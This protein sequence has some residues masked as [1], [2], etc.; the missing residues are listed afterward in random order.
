MNLQKS[1]LYHNICDME[2][3]SYIKS[4]FGVAADLMMSGMKYLGYHIKPCGYKVANW[5]WLV[6]R[7]FKRIYGW[8]FRCL[9]MGGHIILAQVVLM[10]LGVYW[11]HLFHLPFFIMKS[12]NR[13]TAK[14]L[15]THSR[16]KNK[17]YLAKM[18][19]ITILKCMG[20]WGIMNLRCF[21]W[22]LLLKSLRRGIFGEGSW[23]KIIR[24]KY[25]K[26]QEFL[27][28]YHRRYIGISSSSTI[29]NNFKE[30]DTLFFQNLAWSMGSG[31]NIIIESDHIL[32]FGEDCNIPEDFIRCLNGRGIFFWS[33]VI[34]T[35]R[36]PYPS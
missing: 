23:G 35:W 2:V 30:I 3:V 31:N 29:W 16:D 32:G 15:W 14:Y 4:L 20:G 9:S 28:W 36:G 22:P 13:I 11:D 17:F 27:V 6:D 1:I 5:L 24:H 26:D 34:S 7:F 10:W 18:F 12:L 8:E 25:Q 33:Q 21:G 19:Q